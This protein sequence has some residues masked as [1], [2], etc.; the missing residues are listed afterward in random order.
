[1]RRQDLDQLVDE[2]V[3]LGRAS[4]LPAAVARSGY[5][6]NYRR[7]LAGVRDEDLDYLRDPRSFRP[8]SFE[9][10]RRE[11]SQPGKTATEIAT[12]LQYPVR[13]HVMPDG[14][15]HLNDGRHR[16]AVARER[17]AEAVLVRA[18]QY[19]PR[20]GVR[21]DERLVVPLLPDV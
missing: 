2:R 8:T 15:L 12:S 11:F 13:I 16:L 4:D 5:A 21:W 19:G 1:V 7:L 17:G 9:A 3:A 6:D 10:A 18:V 14:Q 20:G